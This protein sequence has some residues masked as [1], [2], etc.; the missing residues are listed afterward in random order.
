MASPIN[1]RMTC[2]AFDS[3]ISA[4]GILSIVPGTNSLADL[5]FIWRY[6]V[7][8]A[9]DIKSSPLPYTGGCLLAAHRHPLNIIGFSMLAPYRSNSRDQSLTTISC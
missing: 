5:L 9:T 2:F 7:K 6:S 1:Q 8:T 3:A 4:I